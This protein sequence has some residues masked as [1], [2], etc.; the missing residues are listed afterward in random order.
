MVESNSLAEARTLLE[1]A[2]QPELLADLNE[3]PA[4]TQTALAD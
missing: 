4:E 3:R 2:Y 1:A